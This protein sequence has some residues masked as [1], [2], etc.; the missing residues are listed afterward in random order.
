MER[1]GESA[2]RIEGFIPGSGAPPSVEVKVTP[3]RTITVEAPAP[4]GRVPIVGAVRR[5]H[6]LGDGGGLR[7]RR[8]QPGE[9]VG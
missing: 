9:R 6:P 4:L 5:D 1:E 8:V 2:R 3:Y 7:F